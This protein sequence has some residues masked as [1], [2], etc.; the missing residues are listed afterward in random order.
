MFLLSPSTNASGG[1]GSTA[2]QQQMP[3]PL[4][5]Q[6]SN[7][8]GNRS[9]PPPCPIIRKQVSCASK[10]GT[11]LWGGRTVI[12]NP[13]SDDATGGGGVMSICFGSVGLPYTKVRSNY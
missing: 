11:G 1:E 2:N 3:A 8:L 4:V 9:L 12:W 5:W 10:E 6:V 7:L 13:G